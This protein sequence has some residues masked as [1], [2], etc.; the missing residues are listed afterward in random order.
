MKNVSALSY[1]ARLLMLLVTLLFSGV[2]ILSSCAPD[3]ASHSILADTDDDGEDDGDDAED[4]D[5]IFADDKMDPTQPGGDTSNPKVVLEFCGMGNASRC[6]ISK[7]NMG[8]VTVLRIVIM[9]SQHKAYSYYYR[10]NISCIKG[11]CIREGDDPI[12]AKGWITWE[13]RAAKGLPKKPNPKRVPTKPKPKKNDKKAEIPPGP[14]PKPK[15]IPKTL[16]DPTPSDPDDDPMGEKLP[17]NPETTDKDDGY[18]GETS[19]VP[20]VDPFGDLEQVTEEYKGREAADEAVNQREQLNREHLDES[21][22]QF[23]DSKFKEKLT[24]NLTEDIKKYN[25]HIDGL[26]SIVKKVP[27]AGETD[28]IPDTDPDPG[29][30]GDLPPGMERENLKSA[31][32]H[33]D[34]AKDYLKD[35]NKPDKATKQ[36]LTGLSSLGI[37]FAKFSYKMGDTSTGNATLSNVHEVLDFVTDVIPGVAGVKDAITVATGINP[38]TGATVS[39][40]TRAVLAA[41]FFVPAVATGSVKAVA[42]ALRAAKKSPMAKKILQ[43]ILDAAEA[44]KKTVK[45]CYAPCKP[46]DV[47]DKVAA[48]VDNYKIKSAK[49]V[50][51]YTNAK[52]GAVRNPDSKGVPN[53]DKSGG[54][55][56]AVK[57]WDQFDF[58]KVHKNEP[59]LKIGDVNGNMRVIARKTSGKDGKGPPTLEMQRP[60][61]DGQFKARE[62]T[63]YK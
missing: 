59:D 3:H 43:S 15:E 26:S 56:Q 29:P 24:K 18:K 63:R 1:F 19:S 25:K 54:Y 62:K 17:R 14:K 50:E 35:Y 44:M 11:E 38:V 8:G 55:E 13:N 57:D 16:P 7:V 32:Q 33:L 31:R 9:S 28:D 42:K 36:D 30:D 20:G 27:P 23:A 6:H 22:K 58:Q 53:Y 48:Q 49:N 61:L 10:P 39:N 47:I 60:K 51:A 45:G 52:K 34:Y 21:N 46:G 41:G 37:D 4:E 2:A 40:S 5:D 12:H